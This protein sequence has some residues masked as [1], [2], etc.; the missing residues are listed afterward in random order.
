M[1]GM[2]YEKSGRAAP[3]WYLDRTPLPHPARPRA[4]GGAGPSLPDTLFHR[5]RMRDRPVRRR[6]RPLRLLGEILTDLVIGCVRALVHGCLKV[7]TSVVDAL[8]D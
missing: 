4:R 3:S 8:W 6:W 7:V 2:P 5:Q 1:E